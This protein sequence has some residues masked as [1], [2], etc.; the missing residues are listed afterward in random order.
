MSFQLVE[1]PCGHVL[2]VYILQAVCLVHMTVF[3]D[4]DIEKKILKHRFYYY[5]TFNKVGL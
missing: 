4:H 3:H 1:M 5:C 2:H